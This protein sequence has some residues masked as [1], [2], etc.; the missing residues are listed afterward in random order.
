[1]LGATLKPH[2]DARVYMPSL[3]RSWLKLAKDG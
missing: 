1:M 2:A 3:L